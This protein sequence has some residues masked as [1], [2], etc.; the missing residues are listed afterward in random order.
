V[1]F[2]DTSALLPLFVDEPATDA[3]TALLSSDPSV[4]VWEGTSVE[5]Q[6]A[7]SRY[8]RH[9]S[10]FDDL[11]PGVRHEMLQR[12]TSWSRVADLAKATLR[13]QRLVNVHPLKTG[14]AFQ[15]A[16]ALVACEDQPQRMDFVTRDAALAS[17]ARLEGF[18]VE[19]P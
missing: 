3:C 8:R 14:D 5:L 6:S 18:R 19:V 7:L 17:A 10:G 16:A 12:W 4:I 1:R 15:L 11:W 2:W 13:A 9:S